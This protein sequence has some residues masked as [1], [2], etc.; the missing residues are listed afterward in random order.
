MLRH[1]CGEV[2]GVDA[3]RAWASLVYDPFEVT[4]TT[5]GTQVLVLAMTGYVPEDGTTEPYVG[6]NAGADPTFRL[7][8]LQYME[9]GETT[10]D[11]G[12][13]VA[14][15][16]GSVR[17][18]AEVQHWASLAA[19]DNVLKLNFVLQ[20]MVAGVL[21][22]VLPTTT[23]SDNILRVPLADGLYMVQPWDV[24]TDDAA[25]VTYANLVEPFAT[26]DAVEVP[27]K[28]PLTDS[29]LVYHF[30]L[31]STKVGQSSTSD[32]GSTSSSGS[33]SSTSAS[34]SQ[35]TDAS[36]KKSSAVTLI[37]IVVLVLAAEA[38]AIVLF[39]CVQHHLPWLRRAWRRQCLRRTKSSS[40]VRTTDV[41]VAE[42]APVVPD[43]LWT[44][45]R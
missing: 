13:T 20:P 36:T 44:T 30:L 2:L 1:G 11:R 43:Q 29:L 5:Q 10:F 22:L 24:T 19:S 7:Q 9:D 12:I 18:Q 45:H 17:V 28:M 26:A 33:S 14:P 40:R 38:L 25:V 8:V 42:F 23:T 3:C 34:S 35:S 31:T 27:V 16:R 39:F 4:R 41:P 37:W 32:S 15:A 21:N 6:T